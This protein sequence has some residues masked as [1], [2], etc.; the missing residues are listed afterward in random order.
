MHFPAD[1]VPVG[2][3]RCKE[4]PQR[5]FPGVAGAL[6]HDV[7]QSAVGLGMQLIKNAGGDIQAMLGGDFGR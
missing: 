7:I 4:K 3:R 5:L 1:A 6:G 2:A